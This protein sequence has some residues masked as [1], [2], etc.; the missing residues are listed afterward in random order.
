MRS[1][2][3]QLT[4]SQKPD[5]GGRQRT[6]AA[7]SGVDR[8]ETIRHGCRL[9]HGLSRKATNSAWLRQTSVALKTVGRRKAARGF[10]SHPRRSV[11]GHGTRQE[12]AA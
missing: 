12:S 1:P 3:S 11:Y 7:A 6:Q 2:P 8:A 10:E 5:A 4:S 9:S